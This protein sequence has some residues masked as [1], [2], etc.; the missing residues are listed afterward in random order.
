MTE[1]RAVCLNCID[2]R[3]QIPVIEWIKD[4]FKVDHVD[5]ITEPGMDGLLA[6]QNYSLE[7]INR[8]V[9]ISIKNNN[10]V[11]IAVTGHYDCR[12]NPA[13]NFDHKEEVQQA[14]KRLR[15]EFKEMVIIGIWVNEEFKAEQIVSDA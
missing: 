13:S 2:G 14:V 8:K 11:M 5:M 12:G 1:T 9:R 15:N 7:D 6:D 4:K 10:A 3:V